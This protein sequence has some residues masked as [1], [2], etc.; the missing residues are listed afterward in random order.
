MMLE[1]MVYTLLVSGLIAFAAKGVSEVCELLRLP[2]RF[3]WLAA[4]VAMVTLSATAPFRSAS[5]EPALHASGASASGVNSSAPESSAAPGDA[6]ALAPAMSAMTHAFGR[7]RTVVEWP[8]RASAPLAEGATGLILGLAWIT[9]S[10]LAI[11]LGL[12]TAL[13]YRTAR[14][15]WPLSRIAG[16]TVRVSP[17]AGPAV[18]GIVRP[19]VVVPAWLLNEPPEAQRLV[20]LHEHE[21]LRAHDPLTLV[22]GS[23]A[24]A[25]IPWNPA[26][27]WMLRQLR[28][29]VELDCDARVLGSGVRAAPYGSILIDVAGHGTGLS[30]GV[31]A[32]AGSRTTL[33]RRL[34]AMSTKFT[35]LAAL[36]AVALGALGAVAFLAACDSRIPT[37]VEVEQ[38]DAAAAEARAEQLGILDRDG[39][40]IY[41]VDEVRVDA[42]EAQAIEGDRISHVEIGRSAGGTTI[43]LSTDERADQGGQ[44]ELD[45]PMVEVRVRE[46]P[47]LSTEGFQGLY[48]IDGVIMQDMDLREFDTDGIES[49]EVVKGAAARM[50][51]DNPRAEH[52]V[53]HI[54]TKK[55]DTTP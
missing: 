14:R 17:M 55:K 7:L 13:R 53:I 23:F 6:G 15:S 52:G 42:S 25:L 28:L 47:R 50:L 24:A 11:A 22:A 21:H 38:M 46:R 41:Y 1:W 20:V 9:L 37:D 49:I 30:L 26:A 5:P 10:L 40:V 33:E 16:E 8:L 45:A 39:S 31:P 54:T 3:V 19:E 36:R 43:Y 34:I 18:L 51:Y 32:F 4:L 35:G 27:W 29:S 48:V 44:V 2:V 12:A